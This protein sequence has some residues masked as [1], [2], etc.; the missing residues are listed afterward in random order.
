MKGMRPVNKVYRRIPID[1][2]SVQISWGLPLTISGDKYA[3][4][5]RVFVLFNSP[6]KTVE[7]PKSIIL[8]TYLPLDL[9]SF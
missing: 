2:T 8:G 9:S 1:H 7:R 6:N 4:L 5:P 3:I